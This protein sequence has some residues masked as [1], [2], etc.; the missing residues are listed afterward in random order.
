[1]VMNLVDIEFKNLNKSMLIANEKSILKVAAD[2]KEEYWIL[3]HFLIEKPMKWQLSFGVWAKDKIIGYAIL[4]KQ[5]SQFVHIHHFMLH[6]D[7]RGQGLGTCMIDEVIKRSKALN[8]NI[9]TLKVHQNN[10]AA[11]IFYKKLGFELSKMDSIYNTMEYIVTKKV[12]IHQPNYFPWIGYFYKIYKADIF[13]FLDNVQFTKGGYINRVKILS[14]KGTRWL[15]IPV[16]VHLGDFI[17]CV[18]PGKSNWASSHLDILFNT[19]RKTPFFKDIFPEIKRIFN[20]LKV[21]N[22]SLINTTLIK[23]L[24][25]K[26]SIKCYFYNSSDIETCGVSDGR[27]VEI[28]SLL[29][30]GG[31]YISGKGGANYQDQNKFISAGLKLEY[32]NFV[33]QEYNQGKYLGSKDFH[34]GMS[35]LDA[36]FHL[37][38]EGTSDLI[39]CNIDK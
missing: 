32:L 35:V 36:V 8:F 39:R 21:G 23:K 20:S 17:N 5:N 9:I 38:W 33:Q 11:K 4:S 2:Q 14:A 18:Y 34:S 1:M 24:C 25:Q 37:G 22:L 29:A 30:P 3:D 6:K 28:V 16:N 19:Y 27:L 26:L 31:T 12:A 13:V 15:T 7:Y 10:R